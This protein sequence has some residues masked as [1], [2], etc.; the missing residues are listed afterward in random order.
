MP[1]V[2]H[3]I[4]SR[5]Q[6]T[7][8][9]MKTLIMRPFSRVVR[10]PLVNGLLGEG[11][12]PAV[13]EEC[14]SGKVDVFCHGQIAEDG[15]ER[16]R[17]SGEY[18]ERLPTIHVVSPNVAQKRHSQTGGTSASADADADVCRKYDMLYPPPCRWGVAR[19]P[20]RLSPAVGLAVGYKHAAA[21]GRT[22]L[23]IQEREREGRKD[24]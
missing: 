5:K 9:S 15:I 10:G 4:T 21:G 14:P 2:P 3:E 19:R 7:H 6:P 11:L 8:M 13:D 20:R 24:P 1:H 12:V 16:R 23:Q 22:I 17:C 18:P